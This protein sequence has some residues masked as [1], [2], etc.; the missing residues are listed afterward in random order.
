[1]PQPPRPSSSS[2][3]RRKPMDAAPEDSGLKRV[4]GPATLVALG[5]GAT[6]GAGLFSLTGIAAGDNAGP[7][8]TLSYI[9]A[10]IAC[11]FAGLCYSEL[12]GMIPVAGS[13]YSYAYVTMGELIAW[14]IGWDLVLEYAVGAATVSVSWSGY[15]TSLLAGWGIHLP[16]RFTASPFQT[17][18]LADGSTASGIANVPAAFIIILVSLLLIRGTSASAKVN[19]VI[20]ALK[21]SVIAAFIG[22]GIPWI[23]T[24]N[25]HPFI[26][27]NDGTFGHFGFSGVMRAAGTI[28]FAYIGF[29]ALSTAAQETRNPK[30]DIP[31][32]I[33]GSLAICALAY[34]TFSLVMTGI[35]NYADMAGDP[36]P[37]AT[38]ID[39]THITW[40][41]IAIKFG[42]I[43]GFTSVLLMLLLGQSRVFFAMSR[44][45]LLPALFSRTHARFHTP[46]LSNLFFMVLT[47]L[48]AAFLPIAELGH[49]TS[50]GTLLAFI[51]VC[52]GVLVLRRQAPDAERKFRVAGGP[53][54][55]LAGILSCL[56]VMVSLDGLTW[57]RLFVWL[58]IGLGV[59]FLYGRQKSRLA[60]AD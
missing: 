3:F 57:L 23:D 33:L 10:A 50:I 19:A 29:D 30:R 44:D 9:I 28:F 2:L 39:R 59:Y 7:A 13:A 42:I 56:V 49:M 58:G 4:L 25:Y 38:A 37:V 35:V 16:A 41:Q 24:A 21:L 8:V 47:G 46:W 12:A 14:I 53:I 48:L 5:V 27:P 1:M 52:A 26:P 17:V 31:I 34:V 54:I 11:G 51:I 55:P 15:V 36:A 60:K 45:G 20:V 40:L 22:F 32:G 18:H 43:G 6:I